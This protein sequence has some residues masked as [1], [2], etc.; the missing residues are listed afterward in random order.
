ASLIAPT[1]N[2]LVFRQQLLRGYVHDQGAALMGGVAGHA[3]L[4]STANDVAV[5]FQMLLNKGTYK[6]VRYFREETVDLFTAYGS[7]LSRRGLGFDKPDP[8]AKRAIVTSDRSSG[9]TFGHQGFTGTS[10]WADPEHGILFVLLSNRIY[11]SAEN[12][13][14]TRL[15]VR[16]MALDYIYESLGI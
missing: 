12:T 5:I 4:F 6:G 1:E 3:G 14:I 10:A 11:P 8:D 15:S 7:A 16:T 13:Q 2:D 9:Y